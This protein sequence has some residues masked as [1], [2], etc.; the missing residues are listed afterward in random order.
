[1]YSTLVSA[2]VGRRIALD[3]RTVTA[4]V[5]GVLTP[6]GRITRV[7]AITVHYMLVITPEQRALVERALKVHTRACPIHQTLVGAIALKWDAEL[8]IGDEMVKV[9]EKEPQDL[10]A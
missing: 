2:L 10:G 6:V 7:T 9:F 4:N 1:M 8:Q 3:E 5:E